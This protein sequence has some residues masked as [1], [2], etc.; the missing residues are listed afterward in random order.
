MADC[1]GI[2][3][4]YI[5]QFAGESFAFLL[6]RADPSKGVQM[7]L[8]QLDNCPEEQKDL[9][10]DA[11]SV[12]VYESCKSIQQG[13]HSKLEDFLKNLLSRSQLEKSDAHRRVA[14]ATILRLRNHAEELENCTPILEILHDNWRAAVHKRLTGEERSDDEASDS[15]SGSGSSSDSEP[16]EQDGVVPKDGK[17]DSA[18]DVAMSEAAAEPPANNNPNA[19][20]S[21]YLDMLVAFV[22]VRPRPTSEDDDAFDF[23]LSEI[24]DGCDRLLSLEASDEHRDEIVTNVGRAVCLLAKAIPASTSRSDAIGNICSQVL[25]SQK[26]NVSARFLY[27]AVQQPALRDAHSSLFMSAAIKLL[28]KK[29]E[30]ES[31]RDVVVLVCGA[32]E[33]LPIPSPDSK[34]LQKLS[35]CLV[36]AICNAQPTSQ[37]NEGKSEGEQEATAVEQLVSASLSL[38]R[39]S[40]NNASSPFDSTKPITAKMSDLDKQIRDVV[41]AVDTDAPDYRGKVVARACLLAVLAKANSAFR[42]EDAF[43]WSHDHFTVPLVLDVLTEIVAPLKSFDLSDESK[44]KLGQRLVQAS[45]SP[46]QALRLAAFKLAK[47]LPVNFLRLHISSPA[48][49]SEVSGKEVQNDKAAN[50]ALTKVVEHCQQLEELAPVFENERQKQRAI[51]RIGE[52]LNRLQ[53]L[54]APLSSRCGHGRRLFDFSIHSQIR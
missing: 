48:N 45:Q 13:F 39:L 25:S 17:D 14:K 44:Q 6:R 12:V 3:S 8:K 22:A 1:S 20:V 29:K 19:E 43:V 2:T 47:A 30:G 37:D 53:A 49:F 34:N 41:D 21:F 42:I 46:D 38:R 40:Q 23:H 51:D 33:Q 9:M 27:E 24:L 26:G 18:K 16:E 11:I 54:H 36:H 28:Q 52:H 35:Q 4:H 7:L 15:A 5:R 50:D 31:S 32:L 10:S